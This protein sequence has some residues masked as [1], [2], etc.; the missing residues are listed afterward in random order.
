MKASFI[1]QFYAYL[2]GSSKTI[3]FTSIFYSLWIVVDRVLQVDYDLKTF[4]DRQI[5]IAT[6]EA[7]DVSARLQLFYGNIIFFFL[8]F[9]C[10]NLLGFFIY[11]KR[12]SLMNGA[13]LRFINYLSVAGLFLFVFKLFDIEVYETQ[14]LIYALHKLLLFA[15][16]LKALFFRNNHISIQTYVLLFALAFA[17]YFF[18]IDLNNVLGFTLNPDFYLVMSGIALVLILFLNLALKSKSRFIQKKR[19]EQFAYF[20][21]PLLCLPIISVLKDEVFL[22]FKANGLHTIS[23]GLLFAFLICLMVL[24]MWMRIKKNKN[25]IGFKKDVLAENYLP[26]FVFSITAFTAYSWFAEYYDEIF[27]SGN[28]YLPIMEH[29]LFGVLAPLEKLNTHLLSDYFFGAIYTFFNG[30]KI[31][32]V[33]LYDFLLLPISYTLYYY[34]IYYL[35]RNPLLAMFTVFV[36]PFAEAIMP[37]GYCLGILAIFALIKIINHKQSLGTYLLFFS[38]LL[39]LVLWRIDLAYV[40]VVAM[41]LILVYYHFRDANFRINLKS[42]SKSGVYMVLFCTIILVALAFIRHID[43]IEK[44]NYFL[45]YCSSAQSYGYNT[46]GWSNMPGYKMHYF[47][48]PALV[49]ILL[50]TLLINHN[51][52]NQNK[53]QTKSFVALLFICLFYFLN[54]N[55][56][57][58]RHSLIEWIDTFTASFVYIILATTPFLFL[59]KHG[60]ITK[61]IGFCM[62]A[63][64]AVSNYRVPDTKGLQSGFERMIIKL[65]TNKNIDFSKVKSRI[66]NKPAFAEAK[67]TAFIEFIKNNC[68]PDETFIDFSNKGMLYF[69]TKKE[70]PSWFYQNPL[71]IQDDYLQK[72]FIKDLKKYK[73]PFLLFSELSEQGYDLVDQVPNVL[74]HYRM[75]EFFYQNFEPAVILGNYCVWKQKGLSLKNNLDTLVKW[76]QADAVKNEMPFFQWPLQAKANKKYYAKIV[77]KKGFENQAP[78]ILCESKDTNYVNPPKLVR[79]DANSVFVLFDFIKNNHRITLNNNSKSIDSIMI[80]ACDNVPDFSTQRNLEFNFRKL[81]YVWGQYD[82]KASSQSVLWE[83]KGVF[84]NND[85]QITFD[86]PAA[87]DQL[88]GNELIIWADNKTKEIQ[89]LKISIKKKGHDQ[90]SSILM[91]LL[92]NDSIK[93]YAIRI[94]SIYE[95]YKDFRQIIIRPENKDKVHIERIQISKGM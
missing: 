54:F 94:S 31:S 74:R 67:Y 65:K 85:E 47:V 6:L 76:H 63:F 15:L 29:Q 16:L 35:T 50:I 34:L 49:G 1:K 20:L 30:L 18:V 62:I 79:V 71:C 81:P 80:V 36:F 2:K 44:L 39:F 4:T 21:L 95:W 91:E 56:G 70:T 14:E 46:V 28:V 9:F 45:H 41:P 52:L 27:E 58:I 23:Q 90:T 60:Q 72:H 64:L 38:I 55:R 24:W 68:K 26:M 61:A 42:L 25:G 12:P 13:E 19:I 92:P 17:I 87:I 69:Y 77:F 78:N 89:K 75:A 57:L 32:E 88:S 53:A 37:A 59:Q 7:F 22:V 43:V 33:D 86:L 93:R 66:K 11:L 10:F 5:G 84:A 3:L 40:S 83:Y 73:T 51:Y 48:F 8:A 82:A